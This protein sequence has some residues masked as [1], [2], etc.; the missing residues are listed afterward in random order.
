MMIK[1][2]E[3]VDHAPSPSQKIVT[4]MP[5]R[6]LQQLTLLLGCMRSCV[7]RSPNSV[8]KERLVAL[9]LAVAALQY[10]V[11]TVSVLPEF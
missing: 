9:A 1:L 6:F 8:H 10:T 11:I 4:R 7:L 2:D 3:T 5:T